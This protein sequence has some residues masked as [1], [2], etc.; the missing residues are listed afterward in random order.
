MPFRGSA[1]PSV[2]RTICEALQF[3][4]MTSFITIASKIRSREASITVGPPSDE[5]IAIISGMVTADGGNGS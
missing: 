4:F 5:I 1:E 2:A 3:P